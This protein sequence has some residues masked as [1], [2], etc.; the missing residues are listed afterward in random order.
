[1]G[2]EEKEETV[3]RLINLRVLEGKSEGNSHSQTS[4]VIMQTM[5]HQEG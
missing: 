1:M 2:K 5:T 4:R 3:L